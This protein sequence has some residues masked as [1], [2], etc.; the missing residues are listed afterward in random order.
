MQSAENNFYITDLD[1]DHKKPEIWKK[2]HC[3]TKYLLHWHYIA[4]NC[5]I[6]FVHNQDLNLGLHEEIILHWLYV[7][8]FQFI[9]GN[10][11]SN[12]EK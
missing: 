5:E 2:K 10:Q 3:H 6:L 8:D 7:L 9:F 11:K 12:K 4:G 1:Y